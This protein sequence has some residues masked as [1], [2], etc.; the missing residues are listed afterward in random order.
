MKAV[1]DIRKGLNSGYAHHNAANPGGM[2]GL[3]LHPENIMDA[4]NLDALAAMPA[5]GLFRLVK[6]PDPGIGHYFCLCPF[7]DPLPTTQG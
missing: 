2:V 5:H 1:F 7:I 3:E 6:R 4:R